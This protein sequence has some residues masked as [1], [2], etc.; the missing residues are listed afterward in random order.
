MSAV[1]KNKKQIC[2]DVDADLYDEI[3]KLGL[4]I[5]GAV[6][7][8]LKMQLKILLSK[9]EE[10]PKDESDCEQ[11]KHEMENK[12][13]AAES[14]LD[15]KD[16]QISTYASMLKERDRAIIQLKTQLK[17]ATIPQKNIYMLCAWVLA[18]G[19]VSGIGISAL[20]FYLFPIN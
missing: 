3:P 10:I 18:I 7:N 5:K 9:G 1:I 12:V 20:F 2:I 14:K 13:L 16:S 15:A 17:K 8:G 6:I 11:V 19:L 4:G